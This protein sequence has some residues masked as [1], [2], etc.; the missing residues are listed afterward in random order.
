MTDRIPMRDL[1]KRI[2]AHLVRFEGD[3]K[4]NKP[5]K[6]GSELHP[7]YHASAW[8]PG[9]GYVS[10]SYVNYQGFSSVKRVVAEEYLRLLDEGYVG[11]HY[12]IKLKV[13]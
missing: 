2:N 6:P 4:I 11:K 8:Y 13:E 1:A 9:G 3:P 5:I 12:N 7:Y 10:I